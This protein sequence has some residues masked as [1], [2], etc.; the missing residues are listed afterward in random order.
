[1]A[2][3]DYYVDPSI[4]TD[5]GSGTVGD[6]WGSTGNHI[7]RAM[8]LI[9]ADAT[10]DNI[11]V[12]STGTVDFAG[13][14]LDFTSYGITTVDKVLTISGYTSASWDGGRATINLNGASQFVAST[15]DG[16]V[17]HDLDISGGTSTWQ[18]ILDDHC[19][20]IRCSVDGGGS[21]NGITMG[22][23]GKIYGSEITNTSGTMAG[24]PYL[25]YTILKRNANVQ[26]ST[27]GLVV[28]NCIFV[29]SDTGIQNCLIGGGNGVTVANNLFLSTVAATCDAIQLSS[30]SENNFIV[31]NYIEGF[32]G[33][34]GAAINDA[35]GSTGVYIANRYFNN[36]TNKHNNGRD[37]TTYDN[38]QVGASAIENL[39]GGDYRLKSDLQR[40][41]WPTSFL[42]TTGT[43]YPD[44]GVS[45][46]YEAAAGG[47]A[48][49]VV[50]RMRG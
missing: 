5:T 14:D 19:M 21:T 10:G 29:C 47:G 38:S 48:G 9:T 36:A 20:V 42:N 17:L 35:A 25:L 30:S 31:N 23:Y 3:G 6:P 4:A 32:S 7:Q 13:T 46:F 39:A 22:N 26:M 18:V 50:P 11:H 1:M 33:T 15:V 41:G 8:D 37:L 43:L 27:A 34:N 16:I 44:I 45:N 40:A 24:A 2:A 28:A 49:V 12:K